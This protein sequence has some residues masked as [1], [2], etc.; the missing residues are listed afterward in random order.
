MAIEIQI[1]SGSRQDERVELDQQEFRVGSDPGSEVFFDPQDDPPARDRSA[2]FRLADDGWTVRSLGAG[3]LLLNQEPL[4]GATRIRSGDVVRLSELGPDFSFT[5]LARP[6]GAAAGAPGALAGLD[7]VGAEPDAESTPAEEAAAA[8]LPTAEPLQ[9]PTGAVEATPAAAGGGLTVPILVVGGIAVCVIAVLVGWRLLGDRQTADVG[10]KKP[11][12]GD[13]QDPTKGK[14]SKLEK[15]AAKP[16]EKGPEEKGPVEKAPQEKGPAE[17]PPEEKPKPKPLPKIAEPDWPAVL[18]QVQGGVF[19]LQVE[20]PTGQAAWPLADCCAIRGDTLLT[21]GTA[22]TELAGFQKQGWKLQAR[23]QA[24]G[25]QRQIKEIRVHKGFGALADEPTKRIYFDLALL[26][27]DE[28]P[29]LPKTLALASPAEVADGM[30]VA[31]VGIPYEIERL[32]SFQRYAAQMTEG[33]VFA[34]SL[35]DSQSAG[36]PRLLHVRAPIPVP[37][38]KATGP[39]VCGSPMLNGKGEVVGI[40]SAPA[41]SPQGRDLDIHYVVETRLVKLWLAGQDAESWVPPVARETSPAPPAK[42][43]PSG[44]P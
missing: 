39:F 3:E 43:K 37:K 18:E 32:N 40:Y 24:S 10:D 12:V 26:T 29:E 44:N 25:I 28:K 9:Q 11:P 22:A 19:L 41:V 36:S 42:S 23:N 7:G 14:P 21:T 38:P 8:P 2:E 5:I 17:R 30:P 31:D 33:K 27:I 4:S 16:E 6:S 34:I 35:L 1:L 20:H 13:K 15:T